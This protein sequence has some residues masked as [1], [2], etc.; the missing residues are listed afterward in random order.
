[1]NDMKFYG[2]LAFFFLMAIFATVI[3]VGI[4]TDKF[5]DYEQII[6]DVNSIDIPEVFAHQVGHDGQQSEGLR[7]VPFSIVLFLSA[8][9]IVGVCIFLIIYYRKSNPSRMKWF[10]LFISLS[11]LLIFSVM[12]T[13]GAFD[14]EKYKWEHTGVLDVNSID[15]LPDAFAFCIINEDWSDAP[16][17]DMGHI[18]EIEFKE[19][20]APYYDYKG[21][22]WMESKK[23]E[24]FQALDNST[25]E[26]WTNEIENY[27]VY[28]YYL[29]TD[30]I[31]R[32]FHYD[33]IFREETLG[34]Y[35]EI[36]VLSS[37][38]VV[39]GLIIVFVIRRKRS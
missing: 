34:Y 30:D 35:L 5:F 6:L 33:E 25:L 17:F 27:N 19:G 32:Q 3:Y 13:G 22:E 23:T 37:P 18:R 31:Q 1:M 7:S 29:S 8:F 15:V 4:N 21:S 39:I 16:C 10:Y 9:G 38:I 12:Y 11:L 24:M 36:I 2:Y 26:E 14:A 28:Q 20:W